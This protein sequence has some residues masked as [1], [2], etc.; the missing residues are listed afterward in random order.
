MCDDGLMAPIQITQISLTRFNALGGYARVPGSWLAIEELSY[1]EVGGGEVIGI[2]T[3]DITDQD[4]SGI[5]LAKD[6]KLCFRGV[7]VIEFHQTREKAKDAL[8]IAMQDAARAKVEEHYQGDEVGAPVDFFTHVHDEDRL[9]P[10][11]VQLTRNEGFSPA[12]E[13]I[14]PLMRWHEDA[15]GNFVEQFQTTGFDQRIWELYLFAMLIE[16]G[17]VLNREQN[18]PDFCCSGLLGPLFIEAVTV[19]P[20]MKDG[21]LVPPP[22]TDTPEEMERNLK[23]YMPIKFGSPL[24]SKLKKKYWDQPNVKGAPLVFAVADFSSPMSMVHTQSAFERYLF[25][26]EQ[27]AKTDANG[28]LT[29]QPE[30]IE[31]HIWGEKRGVP[32]GFFRLPNAQN[33]SAVVS[34]NAGTIAKFNRLGILGKFGS[35]RVLLTRSGT[36]VDHNPNARHPKLFKV[37]VNAAGY[38]EDWIEGLNVYHNPNA[39]IPLPMEMLPG[40]AH[41]FCDDLGQVTSY[42]PHFHPLGS[43]TEHHFPVDVDRMLRT[44]GDKTHMVWTPKPDDTNPCKSEDNIGK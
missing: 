35:K 3:K 40:A 9:H 34:S 19:G 1:F 38:E 44:I 25:G 7:D 26:Y 13:I 33:V 5:V 41:H 36:M 31:Q 18:I 20:T 6:Q 32:S 24:Y 16:A 27:I 30:Q 14:E 17:Y 23:D 10:S 29:I 22:P 15:D 37:V 28:K 11:F 43:I 21:K 39:D 4:F 12:R 2:V 42:T 8:F